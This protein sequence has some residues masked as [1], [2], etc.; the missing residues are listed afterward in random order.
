MHF[1]NAGML[2]SA[3][4]INY[5]IFFS[6]VFCCFLLDLRISLFTRYNLFYRLFVISAEKKEAKNCNENSSRAN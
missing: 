1:I 5:N 2:N 6:F 4:Y 3:F